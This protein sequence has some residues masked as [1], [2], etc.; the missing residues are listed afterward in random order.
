MF[1]FFKHIFICILLIQSVTGYFVSRHYC[2]TELISVAI[3]QEASACCDENDN[4]CQNETDYFQLE[5]EF[6]ITIHQL[7]K[8]IS[9]LENLSPL[10]YSLLSVVYFNNPTFSVIDS[11]SP[12]GKVQERLSSLQCYLC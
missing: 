2:G 7:I 11:E 1:K 6:F 12:P 3:N 5:D 9:E 10:I 8:E 4:C